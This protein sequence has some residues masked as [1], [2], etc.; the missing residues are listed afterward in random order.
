MT[1]TYATTPKTPSIVL[2]ALMVVACWGLA[3]F[4]SGGVPLLTLLLAAVGCVPAAV[5]VMHLVV[6]V[7]RTT[8]RAR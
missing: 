3:W 8:R 6:V 5:V 4:F 1:T 7:M 2:P